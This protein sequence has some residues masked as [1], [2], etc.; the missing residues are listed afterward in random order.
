MFKV[1]IVEDELFMREFLERCIN[2]EELCFNICG[3][4][5]CAEDALKGLKDVQPD[6]VITDIKMSG[7]DGITFMSEMLKI[8]PT[9]HFIVI[10]NYQDFELVR[11]AFRIGICDYIP[12]IDFEIEHYKQILSDFAKTVD[13]N[14]NE[15]KKEEMKNLKVQFW[16][17]DASSNNVITPSVSEQLM[18]FALVELLNYEDVVQS[19]WKMDKE[20]LKVEISNTVEEKFQEF[21]DGDFFFNEYDKLVLLFSTNDLGA[22]RKFICELCDVFR[23]YYQFETCVLIEENYT[24]LKNLKEKYTELYK[25]KKFRFFMPENSFITKNVLTEFG[26]SFDFVKEYAQMEKLLSNNDFGAVIDNLEKIKALRPAVEYVEEVL[27]FYQNMILLVLDMQ[28]KYKIKN[29]EFTSV[30]RILSYSNYEKI[31]E[32]LISDIKKMAEHTPS[33]EKKLNRQIDEYIQKNYS[34]K[35]SLEVMAREF[36]YEYSYFSKIFRKIKGVT[37]KKYLNDFRLEKAESLIRHTRLK[38]S[39]IA[40][41]VGY[42]NYEHFSRCFREKYGLWPNEIERVEDNV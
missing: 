20:L 10:S 35:I 25:M 16:S 22:I 11:S 24:K 15:S 31:N 26:D 1:A 7:M 37:F 18:I 12:K 14:V 2:Y 5:C 40:R 17:A 34:K 29:A 21:T 13:V 33:T 42:L 4:F 28:K 32:K 30:N 38:Y 36:Q 41:E 27:C 8:S 19:R 39:E 6:L 23:N 9:T 3:S